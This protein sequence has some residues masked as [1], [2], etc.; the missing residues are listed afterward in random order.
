MTDDRRPVTGG[1]SNLGFGISNLKLLFSNS[2]FSL[3]AKDDFVD[4]SKIV[5]EEAGNEVV[6]A[7]CFFAYGTDL[8]SQ[9]FVFDQVDDSLGAFFRAVDEIAILPVINL[10]ANPSAVAT[11]HRG[12]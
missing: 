1:I 2:N 8:L 7:H 4:K 5:S 9:T 11:D 12:R 3:D 6:L 10:D